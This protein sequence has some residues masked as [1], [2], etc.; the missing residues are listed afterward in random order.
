M[1]KKYKRSMR[2]SASD[3]KKISKYAK[4]LLLILSNILA[5]LGYFLVVVNVLR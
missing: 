3:R 5:I 4:M 2:A 1:Q